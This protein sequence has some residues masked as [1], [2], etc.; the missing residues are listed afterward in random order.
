MQAKKTENGELR[1]L[2]GIMTNGWYPKLG[3]ESRVKTVKDQKSL[4]KLAKLYADEWIDHVDSETLDAR[5]E[6]K[7][8]HELSE[9][10][11]LKDWTLRA[12]EQFSQSQ[13]T[14]ARKAFIFASK[15][16]A[17]EREDLFQSLFATLWAKQTN[18]KLDEKLAH[19]IAHDTWANWWKA[20]YYREHY[21]LDVTQETD[22][23]ELA[24]DV[25]DDRDT[26]AQ[27]ESDIDASMLWQSLPKA[28]QSIALKR[29]KGT[30]LTI[31]ERQ[32]LS[33]YARANSFILDDIKA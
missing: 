7:H 24:L 29:I 27:A 22:D 6:S 5:R 28:I 32:R 13:K 25:I 11:E 16:P 2:A 17:I 31:A 23:S 8:D 3:N 20:Y 33:R 19:K 9:Y 12:L 15:S 1:K 10:Q 26:I 4:D 30:P 21:S 14:I 18:G